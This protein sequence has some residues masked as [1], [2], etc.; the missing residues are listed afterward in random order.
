MGQ[1]IDYDGAE[2][3][4]KQLI[5]EAF[6]VAERAGI[7]LLS[8]REEEWQ[9]IK[10]VSEVTNPLHYPSMYQDLVKNNRRTEVD[11]INGYVAS[12]GKKYGLKTPYC[13]LLT[14]E[15]HTKEDLQHAK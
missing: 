14:Q 9:T 1:F 2:K 15:V 8:T 4:G 3:L 7:Q 13:N 5:N 6:D 11:Y 10:Y 12:H